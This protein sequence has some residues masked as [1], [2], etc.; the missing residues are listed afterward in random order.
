MA[1]L[2][3]KAFF[4]FLFVFFAFRVFADGVTSEKEKELRIKLDITSQA[5]WGGSRG[6]SFTD[7]SYDEK[8]GVASFVLSWNWQGITKQ[9]EL[10]PGRYML[11]ALVKTNSFAAK[12]FM[13]K[14][15]V[16]TGDIFVMPIGVSDDFREV[17]LP[18]YVEGREKKKY[19]A[20]IAR[21]YQDPAKHEGVVQVKEMEIIRLGDTALPENWAAKTTTSLVHGLDT[22]KKISRPDRPGKVIFSDGFI[23][24]ELWLMTQG[25][26]VNLSYAGSQDFSND[27]KYFYAGKRAPG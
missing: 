25:G 17:V 3:Q 11:R 21:V 20:G 7:F 9:V 4:T 18:F 5:G 22:M 8:T 15:P 23:G 16:S 26:E 6:G 24:T 2:F 1:R 12:L 19:Y 10:P 27:G 13:D 14:Q